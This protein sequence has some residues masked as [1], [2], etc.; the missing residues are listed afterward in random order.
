ME[1]ECVA[2]CR[3][4]ALVGGADGVAERVSAIAD[5]TT[6][7][8]TEGTRRRSPTLR[9]RIWDG[10]RVR[11]R[12]RCGLPRRQWRYSQGTHMTP[13]RCDGGAH[14][15]LSARAHTHAACAHT[16]VR[17][18]LQ[19]R[20]RPQPPRRCALSRASVRTHTRACAGAEATRPSAGAS[21]RS[22]SPFA[23]VFAQP[24]LLG[25]ADADD[26]GD[27]H[28]LR[29]VRSWLPAAAPAAA[30]ELHAAICAA[31]GTSSLGGI[32]TWVVV[33]WDSRLGK[34]VPT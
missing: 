3:E 20:L 23:H 28:A 13:A 31:L 12:K 14:Y 9:S 15:T 26:D 25:D 2:L 17:L 10:L 4:L 7:R 34:L 21:L 30:R 29:L 6:L 5:G 24:P 1:S 27:A 32:P 33:G 11:A 19:W 22:L 18:H 16:S 8:C